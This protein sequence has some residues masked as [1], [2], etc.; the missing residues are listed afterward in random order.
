MCKVNYNLKSEIKVCKQLN[1]NFIKSVK[2]FV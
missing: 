1:G 2:D